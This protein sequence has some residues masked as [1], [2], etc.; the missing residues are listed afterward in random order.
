MGVV[1]ALLGAPGARADGA[2][3][4][5]AAIPE[6]GPWLLDNDGN[7]AQWLGFRY[8]NRLLQEP[9]NV[10]VVD[11]FAEN[12]SVA[13]DK[14]LTQESRQGYRDSWG[15]SSGYWAM[16]G[17]DLFP[18]IADHDQSALSDGLPFEANNHGRL[19]GPLATAQGFVFTLALSRESFR[20]WS[21]PAHGFVS[22][23][24]ARDDY[25]VR[26]SEGDVY[27]IRG[28]VPL[29]NT[30]DTDQVTTADHDGFAVVLEAIQ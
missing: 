27:R 6:V 28:L 18:Q 15:H 29:G 10:L 1:V 7:P 22:F 11:A 14:L 5:L 25:A 9:I 17:P 8:R 24:Q 19:F 4:V 23:N 3:P 13:T 21:R 2:D 16:I 30:I 20:P 12:A 26:M